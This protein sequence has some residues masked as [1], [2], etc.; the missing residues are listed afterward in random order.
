VAIDGGGDGQHQ[1]EVKVTDMHGGQ[2]CTSDDGSIVGEEKFD[3]VCVFAGSS[4]GGAVRVVH[5]VDSFV[6][7]GSVEEFVCVVETKLFNKNR[8]NNISV[9][10]ETGDRRKKKK[11]GKKQEMSNTNDSRIFFFFFFFVFR[12]LPGGLPIGW[13][14]GSWHDTA[15]FKDRVEENSKWQHQEELVEENDFDAAKVALPANIQFL[16]FVAIKPERR[17]VDIEDRQRDVVEPKH[18]LVD[19]ETAQNNYLKVGPLKGKEEVINPVGEQ[20]VHHQKDSFP[21]VHCQ[22]GSFH[23][24]F[25]KKERKREKKKK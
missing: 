10:H 17:L 24:L 19:D 13:K 22:V 2:E 21:G 11:G 9:F 20:V 7:E 25:A 1:P 6:Q 12:F 16:Y 23:L 3:W 5:F 18:G 15:I 8:S 14:L 4:N